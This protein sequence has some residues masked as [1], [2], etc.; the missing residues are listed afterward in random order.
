[1]RIDK[2]NYVDKAEQVIKSLQKENRYG[3]KELKL[4][5]SKIR[6]ILSMVSELYNDAVHSKEAT[7][8]TD[9][10]SRVQYLK[11]RV[12]Y[13]A[14]RDRDVEEFVR[15]AQILEII[16]ERAS[17]NKKTI[18]NTNLDLSELTKQYSQ[19]FTSRIIEYF[20]TCKFTGKDIRIQMLTK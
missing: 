5:T 8:S 14:G 4:T 7:L 9:M 13:E 2:L 18:I 15:K 3:E 17:E 16:N 20:I 1:M 19:R 11:M 6:N 10:R 12:A